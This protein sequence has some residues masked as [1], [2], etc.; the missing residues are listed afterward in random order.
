ML[1]VYKRQPLYLVQNAYTVENPNGTF[2]RLT[3]GN[4]GHGGDK[5]VY[6]RQWYISGEI[7]RATKGAIGAFHALGKQCKDISNGLPTRCV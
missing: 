6:K 2:P 7:S 1:D 3:L 4:Q 5:D